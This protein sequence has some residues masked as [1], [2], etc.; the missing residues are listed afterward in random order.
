[1][2]AKQLDKKH[3]LGDIVIIALGTNSNSIQRAVK[4]IDYLGKDRTIYGSILME[5]I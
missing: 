2:V 4:M 1:M 5:N 3:K